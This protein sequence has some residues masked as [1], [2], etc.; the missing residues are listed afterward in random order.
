MIGRILRLLLGAAIDGFMRFPLTVIAVLIT[1]TIVNLEIGDVIN[2]SN[3][4]QEQVYLALAAF[5]VASL[6]MYIGIE[7]H[8]ES[9]GFRLLA[10]H[11]GA[12]F[13]GTLAAALSWFAR[14][15]GLSPA[16]FFAG[17]VGTLT[18]SAHWFRGT[19][20][21]YWFF[22]VRLTFALALSFIAV[23]VFGLGVSAILASLDYLFGVDIPGNLY[24][25]IWATSL[26]AAGPLF[27]LGR[28]P[29]DFDTEPL[30]DGN[31]TGIAGLR[32]LSDFLASPL[33][34]IYALILHAY[35]VKIVITG[36]VPQNQIGWMVIAFGTMIIFFWN[37]MLPLRGVLTISGR[38]F[39]KYWPYMVVVPTV[40]LG[41]ALF[42]RIGDYG[43]TPERYFLAAFGA[44]M[45]IFAA[46]QALPVTRNWLQLTT[47]L[48]AMTLLVGSIGP[49]GAEQVSLR[50]QIGQFAQLLNE[51]SKVKSEEGERASNILRYLKRRDVLPLLKGLASEDTKELF[52]APPGEKKFKLFARVEKAFQVD[53]ARLKTNRLKG[54]KN[55]SFERGL[56][57]VAG[58]DL[59]LADISFFPSGSSFRSSKLLPEYVI[60]ISK[61]S[62][63]VG[64]GSVEVKFPLEQLR[65]FAENTLPNPQA[66]G[67]ELVIEGKK[68]LI[69]PKF[70]SLKIGEKI[71]LKSGS[72]SIFLRKSDWQ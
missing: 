32:L 51:N 36:E 7:S 67:L 55:F 58:Y 50:S 72:G 24:A 22:M 2:M 27:V 21:G 15:I 52:D 9:R 53:A 35:A 46:M 56:V 59:Q 38:M 37:V 69:V 33:L 8:G 6:M 11:I 62:I 34:V 26:V 48:T 12:A 31:N 47:A 44:L 61:Y 42:L 49:W 13:G 45:L 28:I 41:Y 16:A 1:A 25:Y 70:L 40:L 71:E 3:R 68:I 20:A 10:R 29:Q 17:L 57:S 23:M 66:R 14:D 4:L 43:F 19:S 30:V 60:K 54:R 65:S 64:Y 18:V 5:S 39:L 63:V